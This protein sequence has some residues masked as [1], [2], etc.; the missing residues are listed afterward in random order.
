MP[1]KRFCR[2]FPETILVN[3]S[4]FAALL[5]SCCL[6]CLFGCERPIFNEDDLTAARK[7]YME[8]NLP[9]AERL[10]ERFLR[11]QQ[12][13]AQRWQAWELL[14]MALNADRIHPRDSLDCL[15]AMMVEYEDDSAKMAEI[16]PQ[17]AKYNSQL[18]HFEQAADAWSAYLELPDLNEAQRVSGFR[19]LADTQFVQHYYEAAE[20]TLQQCLALPVPDHDKISCMLDLAEQQMLRDHYEEVADLARQILDSEPDKTIFGKACYLL[21]DALEQLGR[22]KEALAA[23]E[24]A[25]DEYPNPLVIENRIEHLKK[26]DNR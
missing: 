10:L 14:L 25:R 13:S 5:F 4:G 18:R 7:A 16:L 8:R 23:F 19:Q 3:K 22:K 1:E 11:E 2:N 15:E 26:K 9:L 12:D 20:E 6:L 24:K 17:I 21:A